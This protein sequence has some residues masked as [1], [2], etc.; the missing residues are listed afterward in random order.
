[1]ILTTITTPK[2]SFVVNEEHQG[3]TVW[4]HTPGGLY[5]SGPIPATPGVDPTAEQRAAAEAEIRA[6]IAEDL[7]NDIVN[8]G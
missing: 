6:Q 1:M 8:E 7:A 2:A 3:D 5:A 4:W